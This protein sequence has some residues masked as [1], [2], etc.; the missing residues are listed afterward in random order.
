MNRILETEQK[1]NELIEENRLDSSRKS[2]RLSNYEQLDENLFKFMTNV[3][4]N[5]FEISGNQL[6][7]KSL[8]IITKL[9]IKNFIE[10][11]G[12]LSNFKKRRKTQKRLLLNL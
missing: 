11:G 7:V 3:R 9:N 1:L 8:E 5:N 4:G 2:M 12:F 10:S 6:K